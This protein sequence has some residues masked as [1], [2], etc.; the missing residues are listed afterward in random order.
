MFINYHKYYWALDTLPHVSIKPTSSNPIDIDKIASAV[1]YTTP[2]LSTY[3]T[4]QFHSGMR[5]MFD[6]TVLDEFTQSG[7]TNTTFTSSVAVTNGTVKVYK[8]AVLQTI[9]TDYTYNSATGVVTFTSAPANG[10]QIKIRNFYVYSTSGNY[11]V[12]DIYIVDNVGDSKGIKLTKQFASPNSYYLDGDRVWLNHTMYSS[13]E[14]VGFDKPGIG[15]DLDPYDF[16]EYRMTTRDYVVEQRYSKDQSAW[17]RSNLWIHEDTV[18]AIVA[19]DTS[20][21]VT[22]YLLDSIRAVRP[23]I[24]YKG[25][26][27]KHN[28]GQNH[29]SYVNFVYGG[30]NFNPATGIVGQTSFIWNVQGS[31]QWTG[32]FSGYNKNSYVYIDVGTSPNTKRRYY[33]C[34]KTHSEPKNPLHGENYEFWKRITERE[35]ENGDTFLFIGTANSAYDNK[36]Y[37][38]SG[39]GTSITLTEIYGSGSTAINTNDKIVILNGR[40]TYETDQ[41]QSSDLLTVNKPYSGSEIYWNGTAWV[42]GQQKL[43]KSNSMNVALFDING[44]SLSDTSTYPSSENNGLAIFDYSKNTA[45]TV[46]EALGFSPDYVDYGNT[47]G[48][49]FTI[50]LLIDEIYYTST[51]NNATQN[52][53]V[54][55]GGYYYLSL[56]HISEPTRPY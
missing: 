48:L 52:Q 25:D 15:F 32:A 53:R 43:Q 21:K 5:V 41:L 37:R 14:A 39:V 19:F 13:P 2:T 54:K 26:L 20:L 49:N 8:N 11:A 12:G 31:T 55:I 46:D 4:L 45:N 56:I 17:A 24:E 30:A 35:V 50:P 29:I 16:K 10:D 9:S 36:I 40:N 18:N 1:T 6:H 44:V 7:S 33:E 28:F 23:I 47:P 3:N 42:Y 34:I 38:V 22:D 27:Q 51:V